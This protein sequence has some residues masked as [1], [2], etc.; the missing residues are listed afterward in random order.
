[1]KSRYPLT[2]VEWVDSANAPGWR[3][4]ADSCSVITVHTVGYLVYEDR[5]VIKL[6]QSVSNTD[7]MADIMNIPQQCVKKRKRLK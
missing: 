3:L 7:H 5:R 2:W 1:M 4:D 6:A